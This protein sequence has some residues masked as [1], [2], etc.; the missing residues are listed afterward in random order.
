MAAS[1]QVMMTDQNMSIWFIFN[2]VNVTQSNI[3]KSSTWHHWVFAV[4]QRHKN[5]ATCVDFLA[6]HL[7]LI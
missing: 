7:H 3:V 5:Y 6:L 1:Q 2:A 4:V